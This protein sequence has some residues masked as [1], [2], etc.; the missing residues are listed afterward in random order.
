MTVGTLLFSR[1]EDAVSALMRAGDAHRVRTLVFVVP[2][3]NLLS[4]VKPVLDGWLPVHQAAS[5]GQEACL[6][7]L[8]TGNP[9]HLFSYS[10]A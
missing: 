1:V 3:C 9:K 6:R 10:P 8:L 5:Y 4:R 2:G 7:E